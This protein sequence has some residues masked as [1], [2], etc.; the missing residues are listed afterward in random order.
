MAVAWYGVKVWLL[1][2]PDGTDRVIAT[3]PSHS[4]TWEMWT[5]DRK[6]GTTVQVPQRLRPKYADYAMSFAYDKEYVEGDEGTFPTV[7]LARVEYPDE[8]VTPPLEPKD[9]TVLL[10]TPAKWN[11]AMTQYPTLRYRFPDQPYYPL[12]G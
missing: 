7:A 4:Y 3:R 2:S 9:Y 10:D 5:L 11:N 6:D 1:T 8:D 12:T